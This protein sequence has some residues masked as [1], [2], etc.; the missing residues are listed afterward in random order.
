MRSQAPLPNTVA[1]RSVLY[2]FSCTFCF[3]FNS[4]YNFV[5]IYTLSSIK[6][7]HDSPVSTVTKLSA[8][9]P[10][11]RDAF[12]GTGQ[13]IFLFSKVSRLILESTKPSIQLLSEALSLGIKNP[14][15]N[16]EH[17]PITS[18]K[19]RNE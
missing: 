10:R 9:Q 18:A 12:P 13:E 16:T 11:M 6:V 14:G 17:S 7:V 1:D 19:V 3:K 2:V 8:K 5:I 4:L 15:C